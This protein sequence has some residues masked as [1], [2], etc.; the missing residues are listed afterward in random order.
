MPLQSPKSATSKNLKTPSH[1]DLDQNEKILIKSSLEFVRNLNHALDDLLNV[2]ELKAKKAL[3]ITSKET[4]ALNWA[5]NIIEDH[6][7]VINS[8]PQ[9][10]VIERYEKNLR[11]FAK[12]TAEELGSLEKKCKDINDENINMKK[13]LGISENSGK[14]GKSVDYV[15]RVF[16][17]KEGDIDENVPKE[18][19]GREIIGKYSKGVDDICGKWAEELVDGNYLKVLKSLSSFLVIENQSW[20]KVKDN[21]TD[22]MTKMRSYKLQLEDKIMDKK[23]QN[24]E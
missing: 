21:I 7:K 13:Y 19:K 12:E 11:F 1:K 6:K 23:L 18:L 2:S 24:F 22:K 16:C 20:Q 4:Q 9:P 15:L 10:D 8:I 5:K 17:E 14:E 3:E